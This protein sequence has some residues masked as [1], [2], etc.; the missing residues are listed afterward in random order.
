ML[1]SQWPMWRPSS[2]P[3]PR[4]EERNTFSMAWC[5]QRQRCCT[6]VG[7]TYLYIIH[8]Y[9][10][11]ICSVQAELQ[12]S[13]PPICLLWSWAYM[14]ILSTV[15]IMC[16]YI[17]ISSYIHMSMSA[18]IS[19]NLIMITIYTGTLTSTIFCELQWARSSDHDPVI[20]FRIQWVPC[21]PLL[22]QS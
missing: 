22:R 20:V 1:W 14:Y 15:Y 18:R 12:K 7:C 10:I 6:C 21:S 16:V 17:Y 9:P 2:T 13:T 4:T 3:V 11:F 19:W 5:R 8:Y